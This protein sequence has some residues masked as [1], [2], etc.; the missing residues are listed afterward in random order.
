MHFCSEFEQFQCAVEACIAPFLLMTQ[1]S[2]KVLE[3]DKKSCFC[4]FIVSLI[5]KSFT[6]L[7]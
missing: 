6:Y 5:E 1:Y 4:H 2:R 3:Q 7:Q